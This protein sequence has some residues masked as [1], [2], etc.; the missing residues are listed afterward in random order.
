MKPTKFLL[1]GIIP[2]L[3]AIT[4]NSY[5]QCPEVTSALLSSPDCYNGSTPCDLCPGDIITLSAEGDYLPDNGC[6]NWYYNTTSGFNPY[7]G[8]GT[9]IGCGAID[10][11]PPAPCSTCPEILLIWIDACGSESANE[12]MIISSGSGFNVNNFGLDFDPNNNNLPPSTDDVNTNGGACN[13]QV[14]SAGVMA[15]VESAASCDGSNVIAAGP[16]T[17]IPAGAIVVIFTSSGATTTYDFEAYCAAGETIYVMQNSCA[18]TAG[19]FSNSSSTG[20]RT[21]TIELNNCNCSHDITHDTD[22]PALLGDGDYAYYDNGNVEYGNGGCGSPAPPYVEPPVVVLPPSTVDDVTFNITTALCNGGPYY[23]VGIVD[24]LSANCAEIFT[25]EFSFNV[26]C[27]EAEASINGTPCIGSTVTL[28]GSGGDSYSWTGPNGFVSSEQNPVLGPLTIANEGTYFLTV[29]NE[30]GCTDE[31]QVDL[32]VFPEVSVTIDPEMPQFC[33]GQSVVVTASGQ[34]GGGSFSFEWTTQQGVSSGPSV[35][36][37]QAGSFSVTLTDGN[38]CTASTEGIATVS[39]ELDVTIL[40]NPAGFCAGDSVELNAIVAGGSGG[41]IY[42]WEDPAGN[43]FFETSLFAKQGGLYTLIVTDQ[44]GC[45]GSASMNVSAFPT[46]ILEVNAIPALICAGASTEITATASNG[47]GNYVYSWSTPSG[48]SNSNPII[49]TQ[50]GT[51]SVTVTDDAGCQAT[52]SI[53]IGSAPPLTVTFNPDPATFCTGGTLLLTAMVSGNQGNPLTYTWTTPSGTANGNPLN[54]G[55]AGTY[56]V[57]VSE[58]NGCTG[59]ASIEVIESQGLS[60]QIEPTSAS[61]CQGGAIWLT[62]SANGGDGNYEYVWLYPTGSEFNDSL[63]VTEPGVYL[64]GAVDGNGCEGLDSIEV[65]LE[66]PVDI[67]ILAPQNGLCPG[68]S[69][70]LSLNPNPASDWEVVWTTPSGAN[71]SQYPLSINEPGNYTVNIIYGGGCTSMATLN[72]NNNPPPQI[73]ITPLN[74]SFCAGGNITLSIQIVSGGP[75]TSYNWNGPSGNSS[76]ADFNVNLAGNYSVT[77]TND[78]GCSQIANTQV[79]ISN[80]LNV[81]FDNPIITICSGGETTLSPLVTG[82]VEPYSYSWNGPTGTF[83]GNNLI[84]GIAGIYQV[85]VTDDNGCNGTG[86]VTLLL[87]NNLAVSINPSDPGFCPGGSINLIAEST[88]GQPPYNFIWSTPSGMGSDQTFSATLGGQYSVTLTDTEG[89]SGTST[90]VVEAFEA[91]LINVN[92]LPISLCT[93]QTVSLEATAS[94]GETPYQFEW[95][96]PNGIFNSAIYP[97]AG[98][99][100]YTLMVTDNNGCTDVLSHTIVGTPGLDVAINSSASVI[101]GN[102]P[103]IATGMISSGQAPYNFVWDTPEGMFNTASINL[104]SPGALFLTVTDQ[105]GCSGR[106]TLI[107]GSSALEV[108]VNSNPERCS[109][110]QDGEIIIES[111]LQGSLPLSI[112]INGQG[113]V[114]VNQLPFVFSNLTSG[115]Y[116]LG[117]TDP[118]GCEVVIPVFVDVDNEP[119][120]VFDPAEI[121]I[122]RGESVLLSPGYL[123]NPNEYLWSPASGLSCTDCPAPFASPDESTIYTIL[124]TDDSGCF[125]EAEISIILRGN[126]RV[127]IPSAFSPN[128]DGIND[129]FYIQAADDNARVVQ[130]QIF[131]RWGNALFESVDSP[132]NDPDFGWDGT[133][134]GKRMN[135]GVFVYTALIRFPDGFERLYKGEATI[136]Y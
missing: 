9:L 101:C 39:A 47:T 103:Y 136:V 57:V 43:I 62:G 107:I 79:S 93:G 112:S 28:I 49:T 81:E 71:S 48:P 61:I 8:E 36:I 95:N 109:G 84:T 91:P 65:T 77:V 7:N 99:G 26:L 72:I 100:V 11:P 54:T 45:T 55:L 111:L 35:S 16:G 134:R 85:T 6:I 18:R 127:Y 92:P 69:M 20:M 10:A 97:D 17:N 42:T 25:E 30:S 125:A 94:L 74:P 66:T 80:G 5:S 120:I 113:V 44:S 2:L 102:T 86:S 33:E 51:Y 90:I 130:L 82:G 116:T 78:L 29:T 124:A 31:A 24:P 15:S 118:S 13:W 75:I 121:T 110:A 133:Y 73:E 60:I 115:T 22:D 126:T 122:V 76:N 68:A 98:P 128:Y 104:S 4:T 12:F 41:E 63:L 106:D 46:P 67:S 38:G 105:N 96:G 32:S 70:D 27:P 21:T 1:F 64:F 58:E 123:F 19:A 14:P 129:L 89:C 108:T 119:A 131:D 59:T 87:S 56:S 132:V 34:G 23:I 114:M 53:I 83:L 50:T 135:S 88:T 117:L 3:L 37:N 52:D 40:P